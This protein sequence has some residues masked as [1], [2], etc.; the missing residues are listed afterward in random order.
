[1]EKE[2]LEK[3]VR[4]AKR[5]LDEIDEKRLSSPRGIQIG[6]DS[7][8]CH[9]Y[10]PGKKIDGKFLTE[11]EIFA[12]RKDTCI[13]CNT[14]LNTIE[15]ISTA[16]KTYVDD[17][18][19]TMSS[20]S[21]VIKYIVAEDSYYFHIDFSKK[22]TKKI[23]NHR[24][25]LEEELTMQK[26][27]ELEKLQQE[28]SNLLLPERHKKVAM[29]ALVLDWRNENLGE[30]I[31]YGRHK[32]TH[33]VD[34]AVYHLYFWD[35]NYVCVKDSQVLQPEEKHLGGFDGYKFQ[36]SPQGLKSHQQCWPFEVPAHD[37]RIKTTYGEFLA[38]LKRNPL[39]TTYDSKFPQFKEAGEQVSRQPLELIAN[40]YTLAD[41]VKM[42]G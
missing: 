30:T 13:F 12:L 7:F 40:S 29:E 17:L 35:L 16:T 21:L 4:N 1:M 18:D 22:L 5:C 2:E 6:E 24:N 36:F 11:R 25:Q 15:T 9:V 14:P 3:E 31:G 39:F 20:K 33:L 42:L 34:E 37:T 26:G 23:L 28:W 19:V 41:G 32:L 10:Q 8:E 27:E 38:S